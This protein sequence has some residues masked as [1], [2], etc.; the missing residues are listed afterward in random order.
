MSPLWL[1]TGN[2][3]LLPGWKILP[4]RTDY[5]SN[6]NNVHRF[7][8]EDDNNVDFMCVQLHYYHVHQA[9]TSTKTIR[10]IQSVIEGVLSVSIKL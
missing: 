10:N 7:R 4:T 6:T 3:G 1:G 9:I 8:C 2:N 5:C